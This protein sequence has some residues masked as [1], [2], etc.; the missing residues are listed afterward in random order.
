MKADFIKIKEHY[1]KVFLLIKE[2]VSSKVG[3]KIKITL[4]DHYQVINTPLYLVLEFHVSGRESEDDYGLCLSVSYQHYNPAFNKTDV[5]LDLLFV[6]ADLIRANGE[7]ITNFGLNKLD[8]GEGNIQ[9][10]SELKQI[11]DKIT[12]YLESQIFDIIELLENGY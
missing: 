6:S 8:I 1:R 4:G 10:E 5:Y 3:E 2:I 12:S 7:A 9:L 11:Q